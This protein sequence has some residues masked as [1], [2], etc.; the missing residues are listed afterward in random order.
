MSIEIELSGVVERV[1]E[2][3]KITENFSK[4]TVIVDQRD[5]KYN[6]TYAVE[7]PG[8]KAHI[9]DDINV[10]DTV[11]VKCNLSSRYWEK[12][13]K[14]FLSMDAWSIKVVAKNPQSGAGQQVDPDEDLP[15]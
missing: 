5:E 4:R 2:L 10:G 13:D 11:L 6:H 15:F 7:I 1:G 3:E 14:Y 8:K 9:A 12:G